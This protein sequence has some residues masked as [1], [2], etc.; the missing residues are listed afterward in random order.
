MAVRD[1]GYSMVKGC[2]DLWEMEVD[3]I[4]LTLYDL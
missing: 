4:L 1:K 2:G 3:S